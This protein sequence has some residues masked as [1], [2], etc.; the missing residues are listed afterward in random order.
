MSADEHDSRTLVRFLY[1]SLFNREPDPQG[2]AFHLTRLES[3]AVSLHRLA[4]D[5]LG[6]DE[7]AQQ[8]QVRLAWRENAESPKSHPYQSWG[9]EAVA[10]I[11]VRK[12]GGTTL[13]PLLSS[14]FTQERICPERFDGIHLY[15]PAQLADYDLYFGHF[16]YFSVRFI[17]RDKIRCISMFRDPCQRLISW[18][19]FMRS[20]PPTS[21]DLNIKLA[22]ELT[23]EEF[24]E[25]QSN[26]S[27]TLVNNGYLFCFGTSLCETIAE[28]RPFCDSTRGHNE[29]RVQ[30]LL[31]GAIERVLSLDAIGL[32][33]RFTESVELIFSTLGFPVPESI[34]PENVTDA[35]GGTPV[36]AVEMT[37]RLSRALERLTRYDR[38]IYGAA[39]REFERRLL[40]LRGQIPVPTAG[41][42]SENDLQTPA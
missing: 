36:P 27:S 9:R 5:F 15:S 29:G 13:Y 39:L 2:F 8:E 41:V 22:N 40:R 24:F 12:T 21:D 42:R 11:H 32:T 28:S 26:L 38:V 14:H 10:F 35:M 30:D 4:L 37:P 1:K 7:F 19:R 20:H 18:Y 33:E 3:G 31:A 17:P 16:D 23:V 34:I 6:S 25:H